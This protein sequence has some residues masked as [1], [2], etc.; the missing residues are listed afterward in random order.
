MDLN[1]YRFFPYAKNV[2]RKGDGFMY[3]LEPG[4]ANTTQTLMLDY[5]ADIDGT[6]FLGSGIPA[7][8]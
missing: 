7:K 8:G 5:V 1:R 4:T 3:H 2:A 6:W